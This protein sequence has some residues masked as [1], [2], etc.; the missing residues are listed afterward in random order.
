M[1]KNNRKRIRSMITEYPCSAE[2]G[3]GYYFHSEMDYAWQ[4]WLAKAENDV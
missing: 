4:G 3:E 1:I 2:F